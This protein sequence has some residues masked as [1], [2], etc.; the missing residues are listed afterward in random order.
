[1]I[2][3]STYIRDNTQGDVVPGSI[4]SSSTRSD[5]GHHS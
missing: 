3:D 4:G 1:M 2:S 5:D